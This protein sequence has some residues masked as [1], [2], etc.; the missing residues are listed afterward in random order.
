VQNTTAKSESATWRTH[1]HHSGDQST[2]VGTASEYS[3]IECR[4]GLWAPCDV[5]EFLLVYSRTQHTSCARRQLKNNITSSV[6][7]CTVEDVEYIYNKL[8]IHIFNSKS[9]RRL[10]VTELTSPEYWDIVVI[11]FP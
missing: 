9:T 5:Q 8:S 2:Q 3:R 10:S 11:T 1:Q 7:D 4:W 6:Y